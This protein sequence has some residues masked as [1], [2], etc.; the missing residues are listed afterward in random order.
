MAAASPSAG[1]YGRCDLPW[2]A[3]AKPLWRHVLRTAFYNSLSPISPARPA[4]GPLLDCVPISHAAELRFP[5][6][7]DPPM[8]RDHDRL[9]R[10][11]FLERVALGLGAIAAGSSIGSPAAFASEAP[12]AATTPPFMHELQ[13]R[14]QWDMSWT[15]RMT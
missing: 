1:R 2:A 12:T 8:S 4:M 15:E 11:S 13:A 3:L 10:R 7:E 6:P 5:I 14:S 9:P